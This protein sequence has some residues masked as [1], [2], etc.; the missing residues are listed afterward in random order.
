[1]ENIFA[2]IENGYV[3][4]IVVLDGKSAFGGGGNQHLVQLG[5]S[6]GGPK[7]DVGWCFK[8]GGFH[9]PTA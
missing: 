7:I 1:M 6:G 4:R 5:N 2:L 8:D 3:V 9:P